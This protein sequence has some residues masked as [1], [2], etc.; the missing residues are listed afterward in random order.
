MADTEKKIDEEKKNITVK[1]HSLE[2]DNRM[3]QEK[4]SGM[5]KTSQSTRQHTGTEHAT[6][7]RE[8]D[9]SARQGGAGHS[10]QGFIY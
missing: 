2:H 3:M 7:H 8:K 1:K 5:A 4:L 9:R 10:G 6:S